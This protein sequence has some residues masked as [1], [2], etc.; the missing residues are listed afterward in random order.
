VQLFT[1]GLVK[2]NEGRA[3]IKQVP[4]DG[5]QGEKFAFELMPKKPDEMGNSEAGR[6]QEP[7]SPHRNRFSNKK[8]VAEVE[9]KLELLDDAVSSL[10]EWQEEEGAA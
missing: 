9:K 8:G 1:A 5:D 3:I 7:N 10:L 6:P 4:V 2:L